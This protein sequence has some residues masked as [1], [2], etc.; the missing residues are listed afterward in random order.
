MPTV[1]KNNK[2]N[3]NNNKNKKKPTEK[4]FLS[5]AVTFGREVVTSPQF[6]IGMLAGIGGAAAASSVNLGST[7]NGVADKTKK[8]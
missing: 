2:S 7:N 8:L 4:S 6:L 3:K 1:N 5:R